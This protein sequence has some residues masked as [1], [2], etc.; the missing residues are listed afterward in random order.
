MNQIIKNW[1]LGVGFIRYKKNKTYNQREYDELASVHPMSSRK[2]WTGKFG[3]YIVGELLRQL[4]EKNIVAQMKH[5]DIILDFASDNGLWEVKTRNWTT[6]GTAGEKIMGAVWKYMKMPFSKK[7]SLFIV[8]VGYQEYEAENK[9][10]LFH[11]TGEHFEQLVW[12]RTKN[13]HFVRCSFLLHKVL[14]RPCLLA[15]KK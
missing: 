6:S 2:Q 5:R 12:W 1:I 4:G 3:E 15:L 8:L 10:T 13:I 7:K 11:P 9:F 14:F